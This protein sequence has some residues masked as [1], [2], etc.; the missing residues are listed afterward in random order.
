MLLNCFQEE[1]IE[2]GCD[3]AGRGCLVG[4]VFAAAVILPKK[5]SSS[6]LTDSKKLTHKQRISLRTIIEEEAIC[7]A[8]GIVDHIEIDRIN[9]L[10]ASFLAM[11]RAIEQLP[12]IPQ[13]LVIED[14]FPNGRMP[15]ELAG[16][17][18]TDRETVDKVEKMKVC[19][20]L[21]PLHTAL[22]VYG[23]LLGY[24]LIAD[25]MKDTEL[26]Q[27]VEKI[28]YEEGLPVVVNP[29]VVNPETF[30][31]EVIEQRL[32]N[33]YIPDMPQRIAT[34]TSQKV[35]I[36]FGETIKAY[37]GRPDLKVEELKYI[38]LAI[39]GW[40]RY[41]LAVDDKGENMTLSSDP[42]LEDLK[43]QLSTIKFGK[44]ETVGNS[45]SGIIS[46]ETLFGINLYEIGLGEKIEN[47]FK[48]LMAGKGAI[49]ATLKKYL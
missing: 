38:P 5:F 26:K 47:Y 45:L 20:C 43:A 28:G 48:E 25:E 16:V 8:V 21:N 27:L 32:P 4:P 39:A 42:M 34:D 41:L 3:E 14:E 15:L 31:K 17:L 30:I 40:L 46:N 11:H 18:F 37:V 29:G 44:P 36:R 22:A 1:L 35:A 24:N 13:Y 33:P 2:A 9:I 12:V 49:R 10:N 19:T 6:E 7:W 23:C